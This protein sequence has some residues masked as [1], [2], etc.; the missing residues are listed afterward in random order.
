ME[1]RE[2][3]MKTRVAV[4][5]KED[6]NGYIVEVKLN[7]EDWDDNVMKAIIERG[8]VKEEIDSVMCCDKDVF[9][10]LKEKFKE[11]REKNGR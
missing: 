4:V 6:W 3:E 1:V 9:E 11:Q 2:E 7:D 8:V 10:K 5:D